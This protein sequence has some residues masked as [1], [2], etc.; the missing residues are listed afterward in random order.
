MTALSATG[1]ALGQIDGARQVEH[2]LPSLVA[3]ALRYD[4]ISDKNLLQQLKAD[5][6]ATDKAAADAAKAINAAIAK[7][8]ATLDSFPS[9]YLGKRQGFEPIG[10]GFDVVGGRTY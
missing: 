6:L 10:V 5:I 3:A 8:N 4:A 1:P 2:N 9:S 7:Y